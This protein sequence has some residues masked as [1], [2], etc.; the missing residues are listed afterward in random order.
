MAA[1]PKADYGLDSPATVKSMFTRA[2]WTLAFAVALFYVNHAEYPGPSAR[3][4]GVLGGIGLAFLAGGLVMVWSSR[5]AK[6]QVRDQILDALQLRG[7]ERVLDLGCGRGLMLTGAAKR[8]KQGRVIGVDLTGEAEAAKENAKVEGV[9]DKVRID[10][11]AAGALLAAGAEKLVY[12]DGQFDVAV[13]AL[14]LH[15]IG[16]AAARGHWVREMFRV[17]KPGGRLA[18][19]DVLRAG[20]YAEA[21]RSAGALSVEV[22][23]LRLLWCLPSRTVT[24]RKK[25]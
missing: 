25:D 3:L 2:A 20:E 21:L 6:F 4:L 10:V 15:A 17:L 1:T 9:A 18:I 24:A 14:A 16:D 8:L 19:F 23:A 11:L 7:D 12:Q 13:S 22:S 5:V